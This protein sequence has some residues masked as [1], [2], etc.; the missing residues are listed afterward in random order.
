MSYVPTAGP[1]WAPA[2]PLNVRT[3]ASARINRLIILCLSAMR[4]R[5]FLAPAS[6]VPDSN[7]LQKSSAALCGLVICRGLRHS[8]HAVALPRCRAR[9]I[10]RS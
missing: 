10:V 7:G 5:A 9:Y 2:R 3:I 8:P 6:H 4:S 1:G